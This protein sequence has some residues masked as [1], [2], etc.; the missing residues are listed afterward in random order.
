MPVRSTAVENPEQKKFMEEN[1]NFATAIK[2]LPD[3]RPQDY[4]RVFLPGADQEIGGAFEKIVTNRDDVT[5]TLTALQDKL[6]GIYEKQVKPF[7][8]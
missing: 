4:A 6:Q 5:K 7:A 2:Q 3:T 1:P 8:K